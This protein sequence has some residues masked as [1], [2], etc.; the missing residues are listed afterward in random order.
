MFERIREEWELEYVEEM[1]E[2][3][4]MNVL[5]GVGWKKESRKIREIVLE[6]IRKAYEIRKRY[7]RFV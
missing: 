3:W 4:Q 6:Y 1:N 2:E 7:T 5:I